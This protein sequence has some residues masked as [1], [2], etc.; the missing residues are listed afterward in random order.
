M[1]N[2]IANGCEDLWKCADDLTLGEICETIECS[3]A[4]ILIDNVKTKASVSNM[5]VNL[6]F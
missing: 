2:D 1:V 5:T 3:K 4:Q 6:L